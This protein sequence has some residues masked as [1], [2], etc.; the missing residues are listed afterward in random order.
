M[1]LLDPR[2]RIARYVDVHVSRVGG[3]T[4]IPPGHRNRAQAARP[5]GFERLDHARRAAAGRDAERDIARAAQRLD[6]PDEHAIKAVVVGH[7]RQDARIRRQRDCGDG[8]AFALEP[9]HQLRRHVLRIRRAP[10]VAKNQ[11]LPA[12]RL[13]FANQF[14]RFDHRAQISLRH[15]LVQ[16]DRCL[17][18]RPHAAFRVVS[19]QRLHVTTRVHRFERSRDAWMFAT[20]SSSDTCSGSYVFTGCLIWTG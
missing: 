20:N 18:N 11:Q 12:P 4:T 2:G 16:P 14:R 13:R 5:R 9:V 10:A 1:D 3:R 19:H 7:R 6:L 8:G 17:Q 15:A